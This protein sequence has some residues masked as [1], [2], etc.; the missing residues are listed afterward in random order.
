[1]AIELNYS[2]ATAHEWYSEY[3]AGMARFDEALE[4]AHRA[5][6]LDPQSLIINTNLGWILY[7]A[8]R[9]D[10]AMEE[11]KRTLEMDPHFFLAQQLLWQTY[12][13]KG[14]Y[15]EALGGKELEGLRSEES[16]ERD[17]ILRKAYDASGWK[18]FQR[19]ALELEVEE[20][21]KRGDVSDD[22]LEGMDTA[23]AD[24]DRTLK[25]LEKAYEDREAGMVWV[26]VNPW[27]DDV[28]SDPRFQDLLMRM[29]LSD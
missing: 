18:G 11:L 3:L 21:R 27:L 4:E 10:E 20:R 29:R 22:S 17:E 7:L 14:M 1:L 9:Y 2:Y 19:K 15:E 28:R 5:E 6:E 13:Q 16:R 24:C 26:K 8:R 25:Q 12:V 23:T